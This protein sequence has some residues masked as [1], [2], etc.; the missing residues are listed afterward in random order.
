VA[1]VPPDH[2]N[3]RLSGG[4][5]MVIETM[6]AKNR[7]NRYQ[8]PDDLI[9]DLKCLQRG[10]SPM[11]A[12][13]KT[14]DLMGLA[15]GEYDHETA[16]LQGASDIQLEELASYVNNRNHIIATMAMILA[17]SV[18]TNLLLLTVR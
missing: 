7:E 1:I 10:E 18:I 4:L 9:L 8:T 15:E 5:G 11:L 17:V 2:L 6:L 16:A 3:T 14:D 13:Q 12:G